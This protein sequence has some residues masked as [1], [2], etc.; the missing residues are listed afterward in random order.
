MSKREGSLEAPTRHPIAWQEADY[1]DEAKLGRELER[2]FDI[3]HGCRRCV[4]LCNAFPTLFDL[5]DEGSTGEVDGV[6]RKDFVKVVDQ[7]Y[8]CDL[9]FMT[10]CPYVP[11]H[12]WNVDFPHLMLR[13]KAVRFR[14]GEVR[15]RDKVLTSTDA[16]G[17]LAAIPVVAQTVNAAN[18]NGAARVVLQSVLG[19]D[20]RREL[21]PYAPTRFRRAAELRAEWPVRDGERTPGKVAIFSTCYINYNEPGIGHDLVAVLAHN[22]I[23]AVLAR[24]EACCGMPKLELGDLEGVRRL[25]DVNIPQLAALARDGYAILAAVPSCALMFKH[26]LPLLFPGDA[27]IKAV[28]GAMFDPFEYFILRHRD[29]LLKTDFKQPLG[30]VSYHIPCHSRVQNI[31]QKTRET[32]QLVPGTEVTTVERCAG[33]DGTW[34]VKE[35]YFDQS[36]KIGRPVFR[37]MAQAAPDF[38]SS[39]CP[40]AARH[41]QQGIRDGGTALAAEKAHPLTLLRRAYGL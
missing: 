1:Y 15:L 39:D 11:P 21:P 6:D 37:Q 10:K 7:C 16:L 28:A 24:Q 30:K 35:E 3:C 29:G 17:K 33:H 26:E 32:L 19:V 2:V 36:M 5:V 9:C 31:G 40:I 22:E 18:R 8:L 14:K 25:K 41:I 13:A 23:P 34:G 12:P 20:K 38:I 4:N 27:D